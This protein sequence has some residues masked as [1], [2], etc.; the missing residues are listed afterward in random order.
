[1]ERKAEE[2]KK[3]PDIGTG[4]KKEYIGLILK[5]GIERA[6]NLFDSQEKLNFSGF[7]KEQKQYNENLKK[8]FNDILEK[9]IF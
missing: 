9:Y 2:A 1:M 8:K 7:S 6:N 5:S 3:N 4:D